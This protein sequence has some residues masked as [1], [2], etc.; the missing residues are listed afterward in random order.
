MS[1]PQR[2]V[3]D[4]WA[5]LALIFGEEPAAGKVKSLVEQYGAKSSAVHV[6]WINLGEVFYTIARKK[7][8]ETAEAVLQDILEL[9]AR[10][11][12]PG[13]NDILAASRIKATCRLSYA[14]AFAVS[15]AD[16]QDAAVCTG[17]PEILALEE[18]FKVIR[19]SRKR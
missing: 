3:L 11:H 7:G 12:E 19:L 6:S 4:A 2:I 13:R 5:L 16:R 8:M 14:D 9:P 10:F 17:D 18:A 1:L 15:L